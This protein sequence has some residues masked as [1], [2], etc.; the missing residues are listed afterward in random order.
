MTNGLRVNQK[1]LS[2]LYGNIYDFVVDYKKIVGVKAIYDTH[3]YLLTKHNI[4]P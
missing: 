3:R 4:R 1:E 2:G